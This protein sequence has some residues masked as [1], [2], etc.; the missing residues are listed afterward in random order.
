[1]RHV[2][3]RCNPFILDRNR[4]KIREGGGGREKEEEER[5]K[6]LEENIKN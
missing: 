3:N 5:R 1:M 2:I 4:I 6:K